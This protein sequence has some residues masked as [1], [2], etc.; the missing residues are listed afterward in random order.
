MYS[1]IIFIFCVYIAT[2]FAAI[3][4]T[5]RHRYINVEV[6]NIQTHVSAVHSVSDAASLDFVRP[7]VTG[8]LIRMLCSEGRFIFFTFLGGCCCTGSVSALH[9]A[10]YECQDIQNL[11]RSQTKQ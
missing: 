6:P 10:H 8:L 3:F 7:L 5:I 4:V 11:D 1:V 9:I 2:Y